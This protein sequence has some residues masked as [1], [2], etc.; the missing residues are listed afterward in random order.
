M[1]ST[2]KV[3]I[4]RE[5][6]LVYEGIKADSHD[7]AASIAR[8]K[9]TGEA[10]DLEDCDGETFY[11]CVDVKGDDEYAQ[12]RWIDFEPE[13]QRKAAPK[14]LAALEDLL[15]DR[16]SVQ[17]FQ[18]IRCGRD[19]R[20]GDEGAIQTGDCPSDDCPSYHARVAIAEA[21]A[22]GIAP[23]PAAPAPRDHD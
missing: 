3:H 6:R 10:D 23:E 4:Y 12:S 9:A 1:T 7:A 13:R 18:C 2:Y 16:P 20:G 5:I 21:E 22:A 15:G 14:L 17:D 8:D 11:A 19:Y